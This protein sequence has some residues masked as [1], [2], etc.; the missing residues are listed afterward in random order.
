MILCC[1]KTCQSCKC[2]RESHAIYQEEV[3][4]VRERLGLKPESQ[5]S[6]VDPR[7]LGYTWVPPGIMSSNKILRYFNTLPQD[8]VPKIDSNGERHREKQLSFQ[9]PKQD[10]ALSY[11][12]HVEPQ[13]HASYE[14]FI[15]ARNEIALDI[16]KRYHFNNMINDNFTESFANLS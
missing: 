3:T 6:K 11:C 15:T 16:G 9:L 10:L 14:D 5:S 8:K 1:R 2:P 13:H 4:S 12:K 7:S